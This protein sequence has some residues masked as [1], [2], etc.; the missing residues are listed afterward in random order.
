MPPMDPSPLGDE[1]V[2]RLPERKFPQPKPGENESGSAAASAGSG[3]DIAH[4]P[5]LPD[6]PHLMTADIEDEEEDPVVDTGPGIDERQEPS[7]KSR[8]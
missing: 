4:R 6:H 8:G 2:R 1:M 3:P 5:A 7:A